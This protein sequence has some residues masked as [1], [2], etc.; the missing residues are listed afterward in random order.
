MQPIITSREALEASKLAQDE[1]KA[2]TLGFGSLDRILDGVEAGELI[3][4]SGPTG[5]GKTTLLLN[6]TS[7]MASQDIG[8]TWF[9]LEV[10]PRQFIKKITKASNGVLPLFYMPSAGFDDAEAE[11][12]KAW[13]NKKKRRFEMIDWIELRILQAIERG[14]NEGMPIRAVFIDHIHQIF[15]I[16]KVERNISL[17]MGDM[18]AKIKE[19]AVKLDLVIFLIAHSKDDPQGTA[20][21]PRK[22]DIRDSGLISR[23]ADTIIM[24]WRIPN[25]DSGSSRRK[26]INEGDN[27]AKIRIFKNRREG[28][29]GFFTATHKDQKLSDDSEDFDNF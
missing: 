23:L 10:T 16:S 17:E 14:N 25:D 9:T 18:V 6:I 26:E 22:E 29:L 24:I 20:R 21:E 3:V 12:V 27:K 28:T 15:S 7:H 19:L 8:T 11:E 4:V 5:E 1:R 2:L 13:E